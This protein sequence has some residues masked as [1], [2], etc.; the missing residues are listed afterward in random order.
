MFDEYVIKWER[1]LSM[2]AGW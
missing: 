2:A 1:K